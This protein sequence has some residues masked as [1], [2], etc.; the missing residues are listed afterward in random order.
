MVFC[1]KITFSNRFISPPLLACPK[2]PLL[3]MQTVEEE[4]EKTRRLDATPRAAC[5]LNCQ[6]C[7]HGYLTELALPPPP[8]SCVLMFQVLNTKEKK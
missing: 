2:L 5:F 3:E 8:D 4:G 6:F 7:L 1:I